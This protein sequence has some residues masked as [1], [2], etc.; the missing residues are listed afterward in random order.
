MCSGRKYLVQPPIVRSPP[1]QAPEPDL[2]DI[3]T[4]LRFRRARYR[5][6]PARVRGTVRLLTIGDCQVGCPIRKSRDQ[7]VLSPPPG[8]SQSATSFIASCRQGIHQTPLSRLIR[9]GGRRALL[10]GDLRP[11]PASIWLRSRK[12]STR[13]R[14]SAE[15]RVLVEIGHPLGDASDLSVSVFRLGK[16]VPVILPPRCREAT[17][18][19]AAPTRA[20]PGTS[21]V[22]LSERCHRRPRGPRQ[23][24]VLRPDITCGSFDPTAGRSLDC[25]RRS[26]RLVEPAGIEPATS[27]LQSTRSPG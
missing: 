9:S 22:L 11:R 3:L 4:A 26:G 14:P 24:L 7:R 10:R 8:L 21:R 1:E 6:W 25:A 2:R 17:G 19:V 23:C 5:S 16:T 18:P 15:A 13:T 27:C 12:S 20:R